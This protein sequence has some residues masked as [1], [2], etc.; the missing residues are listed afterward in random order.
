MIAKV[1][2]WR[3]GTD[4]PLTLEVSRALRNPARI[5][6][7]SG[8]RLDRIVGHE[9]ERRMELFKKTYNGESIVDVGRDVSE[10]FDSDYNAPAALIPQDEHGF[11]QGEFIVT[12]EWVP[13]V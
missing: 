13:N 11:Q 4:E 12:I 7:A 6:E 1:R 9:Q 8:P 10:A 3:S 2:H 5:E